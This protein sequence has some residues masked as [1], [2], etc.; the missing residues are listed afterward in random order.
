MVLG[1]AAIFMWDTATNFDSSEL[2][3]LTKLMF[4][5]TGAEIGMKLLAGKK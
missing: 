4:A 5:V 2:E 1:F 3:C